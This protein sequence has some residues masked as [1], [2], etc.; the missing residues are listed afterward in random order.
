VPRQLDFAPS[1]LSFPLALFASLHCMLLFV[2]LHSVLL[3]LSLSIHSVVVVPLVLS[4]V[5]SLSVGVWTSSRYSGFVL[6]CCRS[7]LSSVRCEL[8]PHR[9]SSSSFHCPSILPSPPSHS[10]L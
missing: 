3:I 6:L 1:S 9:L 2:I 7:V 8:P 10:L 5:V 4:V